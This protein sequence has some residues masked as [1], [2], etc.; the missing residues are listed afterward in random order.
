MRAFCLPSVLFLLSGCSETAP[1]ASHSGGTSS[2]GNAALA[3]AANVGG[4]G[5]GTSGG[6]GPGGAGGGG[7]AAVVGGGGA[8]GGGGS[9]PNAYE[10]PTITWPSAECTAQVTTLLGM[11][12]KRQKAAQ[13]VM[14]NNPQ[15]NLVTST[16]VGAVFA[17]GGAEPPGG[18]A[19]ANARTAASAGF[20]PISTSR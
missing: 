13:M 18:S 10:I 6:V 5:A 12:S 1:P 20:C 19:A 14:A 17:P 4:G 11:M 8:G 7:G 2:G 9:E 15:G 3:G 16:Q